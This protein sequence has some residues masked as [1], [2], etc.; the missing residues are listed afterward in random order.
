MP[1]KQKVDEIRVG[2]IV[3]VTEGSILGRGNLTYFVQ[4]GIRSKDEALIVTRVTPDDDPDSPGQRQ[5]YAWVRLFSNPNGMQVGGL[6]ARLRKDP[7][8][9]RIHEIY[10][11]TNTDR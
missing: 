5:V 8:L 7:F 3:F 9:G 4:T 11:E 1:S 6:A 10:Y 2:D